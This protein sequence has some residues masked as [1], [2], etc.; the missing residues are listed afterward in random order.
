MAMKW[1]TRPNAS[2]PPPFPHRSLPAGTR[3]RLL[4]NGEVFVAA[5]PATIYYRPSDPVGGRLGFLI[6][7]PDEDVRV[8]IVDEQAK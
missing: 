3:L 1:G 8:E 4:W 6:F 2:R 5:K 7:G